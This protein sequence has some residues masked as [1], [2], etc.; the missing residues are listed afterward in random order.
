MCSCVDHFL[1][2]NHR[3]GLAEFDLALASLFGGF[4]P[5]Y[6]DVY[7]SIMPKADGFEERMRLFRLYHLLNHLNLHGAG[8]GYN[9]STQAPKGYY[10]RTIACMQEI[11]GTSP[12]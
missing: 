8:F 10:E 3:Y 12:Q 6:S 7:F 4:A 5:P 9:G 11:L 1:H 2:L